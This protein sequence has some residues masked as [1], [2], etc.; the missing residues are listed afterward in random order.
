MRSRR[1]RGPPGR[2]ARRPG[3]RPSVPDTRRDEAPRGSLPCD[4]GAARRP[5]RSAYAMEIDRPVQEYLL[6]LHI[7]AGVLPS[8]QGST[9]L[10]G[11]SACLILSISLAPSPPFF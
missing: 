2:L 3:P 7:R 1:D 5:S 6:G 10:T 4:E 9:G 11:P 8:R